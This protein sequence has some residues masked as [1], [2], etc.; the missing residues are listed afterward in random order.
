MDNIIFQEIK[1]VDCDLVEKIVKLEKRNLGK[2]ASVNEWVIPV[3]IRYGKLIVA[4]RHKE[5]IKGERRISKGAIKKNDIE[6]SITDKS[7]NT[8]I[9]GVCEIIKS[10]REEN[11]AFIHSFYVERKYRNKG[12]G[13]KLM[14]NAIDALKDDNINIIELTVDPAN[15][16]AV[17]L[18]NKCGFKRVG[19]RKD[20]YGRGVD[21]DLMI[22]KL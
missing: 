17:H 2:D 19:L 14:Q 15:S 7:D 3:I 18:Y 1:N 6:E 4:K 9:I 11:T 20:E 22:L 13:K 16:S 8:E 21:R 12:I 10:L 5:P